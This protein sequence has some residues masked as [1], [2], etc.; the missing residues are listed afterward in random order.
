MHRSEHRARERRTLRLSAPRLPFSPASGSTLQSRVAVSF[1]TGTGCSRRPFARLQQFP[2]SRIPFQ[3]QR[4]WPA[5]SLPASRF[6]C[7]FGPSLRHRLPRFAPVSADFIAE[8]RCCFRDSHGLPPVR[9]PLPFRTVTSLRIKAF[10]RTTLQ[11]GPPSESARFPFAPRCRLLLLG[12]G[13][14]ST[15][16]I[17]Y[18]SGGL[19][20]L[21]PLGT[22]F[23]MRL[24]VSFVNDKKTRKVSVSAESLRLCF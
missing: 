14:G 11:A 9:P 12:C 24:F 1:P 7:P 21:K 8:T 17:R 18:V 2:F 4:S 3:G 13:L 10:C 5:A 16:P 22:L 15:F 6:R 20:F 19:L 23:N